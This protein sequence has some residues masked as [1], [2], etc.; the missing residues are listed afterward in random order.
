MEVNYYKI[1]GLTKDAT[2]SQIKARFQYLAKKYHPD[3]NGSNKAMSLIN[4]AYSVL[5][6]PKTRFQ[7]NQR[8]KMGDSRG[9]KVRPSKVTPVNQVKAKSKP[10]FSNEKQTISKSD[11]GI[12]LAHI[13]K[14]DGAFLAIT[15]IIIVLASVVNNRVYRIQ[16][17]NYAKSSTQSNQAPQRKLSDTNG[18]NLAA[19]IQQDKLKTNQVEALTKQNVIN[20]NIVSSQKKQNPSVERERLHQYNAEQRQYETEQLQY[21]KQINQFNSDSHKILS[22]IGPTNALKTDESQ[23]SNLAI[24]EGILNKDITNNPSSSK[25]L[26]QELTYYASQSSNLESQIKILESQISCS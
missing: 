24:I 21:S 2:T 17:T 4:E 9:N 19:K 18:S 7:Y 22:C 11:R 5:S 15:L 26:T 20:V 13:L 8:L 25:L 3:H 6:N 12:H 10:S 23:L 14:T 16:N 1:L